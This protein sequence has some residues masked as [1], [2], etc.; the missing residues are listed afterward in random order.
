MIKGPLG[1]ELDMARKLAEIEAEER[2]LGQKED[3]T[4]ADLAEAR[5]PS[6]ADKAYAG[7]EALIAKA[8]AD[9]RQKLSLDRE[10]F[11]ALDRLPNEVRD[12]HRVVELDFSSTRVSDLSPLA[13]MVW[14]KELNFYETPVDD[15]SPVSDLVELTF[16]GAGKT[17]VN[18]LRP[19]ENLRQLD[20]LVVSGTEISDIQVL[21]RLSRLEAIWIG[22]TKVRTFHALK[23]LP[24]LHTVSLD[25]MRGADYSALSQLE[26]LTA[27]LL[28]DSDVQ[29]IGFV[30]SMTDL[31]CLDIRGTAV[32]DLRPAYE[33]RKILSGNYN[34]FFAD[35]EAGNG[36]WSGIVFEGCQATRDDPNLEAISKLEDDTKRAQTLFDYLEDWVP[37]RKVKNHREN[38][39]PPQPG[40]APLQTEILDGRLVRS[41]AHGLPESD[42]MARAEAGWWALK[43]YRK[44][45]GNSCNVHNYGQLVA[46]LDGFDMA[47]GET[48]D[49]DRL[50]LIGTMGSAVVAL[51]DDGEF[52]EMLPTGASAL[53]G[54]FG[55]QIET[56]LNRFP[57]WVTY[58]EE[59]Q[60]TQLTVSDVVSERA[61]FEQIEDGLRESAETD[62]EVVEDYA[63]QVQYG[64]IE[65]A[66]PV[67]AKGLV[68]STRETVRVLSEEAIKG[69]QS[70][71]LVRGEL[72][73][74]D[75]V[76]KTELAK[77]KWYAGGWAIVLLR[78]RS[79]PLRQLSRRFPAQMGWVD[80]ILDYIGAPKGL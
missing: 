49:P 61:V 66:D 24:Y 17:K 34:H 21:A 31:N 53:L 28:E 3:A 2:R 55:V 52:C 44:V 39:T 8:K 20:T 78:R 54:Q 33:N 23:S 42:A 72:D 38:P 19:L 36:S 47:M 9:G 57:D 46:V 79:A 27:L 29:D 67:V 14:L 80:R 40:I 62:R 16:L 74:I 58:K 69:V 77:V 10:E 76:H 12:L 45:F 6:E 11:R 70:G 50:I 41:G 51:S 56:F 4:D 32:V 64:A 1:F 63:V 15:L 18:D 37:P 68:A 48:F 5:V 73:A 22:D 35:D 75:T 13:D 7:A 25:H 30:K 59:A 71:E 60:G 26:G 43:E 65:G